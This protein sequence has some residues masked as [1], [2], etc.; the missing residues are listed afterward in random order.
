MIRKVYQYLRNRVYRGFIYPLYPLALPVRKPVFIVGCGRS[1]TT[2]LGRLIQSHPQLAYL[3]EAGHIW[4]YDPQVDIWGPKSARR[5]GRLSL[6]AADISD[7]AAKRVRRAFAV[8]LHRQGGDII[9]EKTPAHSFRIDYLLGI[10]PDARFIHMV[11]NGV[12]VAYSIARRVQGGHWYK[13]RKWELL[14]AHARAQGKD[15]L[16]KLC[17]DEIDRGLLEWR[18]FVTAARGD[19]AQ[20]PAHRRLEIH[21]RDLIANPSTVCSQIEAFIGVDTSH[22]MRL[23]AD[24]Q[25][26]RRSRQ[27]DAAS[28]AP[29]QRQ[30]GGD[31]LTDLHMGLQAYPVHE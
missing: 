30:I 12:E 25:I 6:S 31:L 10:F 13:G 22:E 28:L 17:Q 27:R 21:Y 3:N 9:V 4:H 8:E 1:G 2:I 5:G 20:L 26:R 23:F 15:N 16:V 24:N 19:L 29:R 7:R 18:L 11:R 14:V